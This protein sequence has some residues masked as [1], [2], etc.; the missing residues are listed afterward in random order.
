MDLSWKKIRTCVCLRSLS[1]RYL[2]A[3]ADPS[4]QKKGTHDGFLD[5][6]RWY[7]PSGLLQRKGGW[8]ERDS[9]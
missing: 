2:R 8:P 1:A 4:L 5:G 7:L 3:G 6:F 9:A